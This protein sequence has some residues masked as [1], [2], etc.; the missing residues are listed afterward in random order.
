ME[1]LITKLDEI[2]SRK[3]MESFL[4]KLRVIIS[5]KKYDMNNIR[6]LEKIIEKCRL[7]NDKKC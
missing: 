3:D 4:D 5:N 6:L 7:L 2:I 1:N